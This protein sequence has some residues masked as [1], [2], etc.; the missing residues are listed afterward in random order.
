MKKLLGLAFLC[1]TM[2]INAQDKVYMMDGSCR[3]VK[4]LEVTPDEIV[5]D[6]ISESGNPVIDASERISRYDVILVEYKNGSVDVFNQPQKSLIFNAN[7]TTRKEFKKDNQEFAFNLASINTLALCNADI[8]GFFE[9]LVAAKYLGLGAMAS[10]NFNDYIVA[11]N[12]F[13]GIL[14]NAKKNYDIGAFINFYPGHFKRRTTFYMG[15]MFKYMSFNFDKVIE[16][17][18][19]TSTNVKYVPTKGYQLATIVNVGTHSLIGKNF[20]F[21]TI[22]GIGAFK[23]HGDYKQQFNYLINKDR[24]AGQPEVNYNFLPKFYLGINFGFFF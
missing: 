3:Q 22:A 14:Y 24:K 12:G 17:V 1:L 9:R 19:G 15:T 5:I 6:P 18:N 16:E 2:L 4:V 7:G 13:L 20:F 21:K 10:Y 23:L 11:P 8:A